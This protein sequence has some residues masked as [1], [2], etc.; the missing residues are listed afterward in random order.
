MNGWSKKKKNY[1]KNGVKTWTT[2]IFVSFAFDLFEWFLIQ[3]N[4]MTDV[5]DFQLIDGNAFKSYDCCAAA[6]DAF[7]KIKL[8]WF[9][10]LFFLLF[11][12]FNDL[13]ECCLTRLLYKFDQKPTLSTRLQS[14]FHFLICYHFI[15]YFNYHWFWLNSFFSMAKIYSNCN[16][17][18]FTFNK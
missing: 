18:I 2:G 1:E 9:L 7:I 12:A 14:L 17:Q 16:T 5:S 15:H 4:W 11:V 6:I 3:F 8:S 10:I 13:S